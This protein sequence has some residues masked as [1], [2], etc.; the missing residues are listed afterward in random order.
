MTMGR[1]VLDTMANMCEGTEASPWG[2]VRSLVN[3]YIW[4]VLLGAKELKVY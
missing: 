2:Y 3:Y 4:V 1:E